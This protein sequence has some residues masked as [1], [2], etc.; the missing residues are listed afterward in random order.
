MTDFEYSDYVLIEDDKTGCSCGHKPV[1]LLVNKG[2]KSPI[3]KFYICFGCH[4]VGE[5]GVGKVRR[6]K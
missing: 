1:F 4:F 2:T 5:V 6:K 3:P